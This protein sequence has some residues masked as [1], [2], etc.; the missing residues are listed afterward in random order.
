MTRDSFRLSFLERSETAFSGTTATGRTTR[1]TS[2]VE[3]LCLCTCQIHTAQC[4]RTDLGEVPSSLRIDQISTMIE[5][6]RHH[7]HG[8]EVLHM[9]NLET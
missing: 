2:S 4:P 9:V 7:Q 8:E 6:G 5:R 3:R 1:I